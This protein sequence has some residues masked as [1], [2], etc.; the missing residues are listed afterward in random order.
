M[1]S[2]NPVLTS[3]CAEKFFEYWSAGF[4]KYAAIM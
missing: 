1:T 2:F 4:K 3:G